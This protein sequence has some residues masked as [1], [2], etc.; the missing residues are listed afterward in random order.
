MNRL[1]GKAMRGG[2]ARKQ[3][4]DRLSPFRAVTQL[5]T[6]RPLLVCSYCAN[7]AARGCTARLGQEPA[8]PDAAGSK[9]VEC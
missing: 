1:V 5:V 8:L 6:M 9:R 2:L 3:W 4:C 7:K